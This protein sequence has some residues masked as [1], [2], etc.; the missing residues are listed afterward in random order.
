M[1]LL[2]NRLFGENQIS[3]HYTQIDGIGGR[4]STSDLTAAVDIE[5]GRSQRFQTHRAVGVH[6]LGGNTDFRTQSENKAVGKPCG[7]I[8]IN[9]CRINAFLE[10]LGMGNALSHNRFRVMR[11]MAIN[12]IDGFFHCFH[13]FDRHNIVKKLGTVI[14]LGWFQ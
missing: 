5:F 6:F 7:R 9:R 2:L 10:I 1:F 12:P 3:R 8:D 13:Y 14:F 11:R 4:F